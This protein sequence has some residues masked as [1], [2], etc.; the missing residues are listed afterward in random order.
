MKSNSVAYDIKDLSF[1]QILR[2]KPIFMK[3]YY[4]KHAKFQHA[5]KE[6]P[7]TTKIITHNPKAFI[8]II[9]KRLAGLFLLGGTKW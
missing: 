3:Y 7:Q 1:C 5:T 4:Q 8:N 6:I 9:K 2:K